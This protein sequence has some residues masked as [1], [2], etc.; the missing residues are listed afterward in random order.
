VRNTSKPSFLLRST[1]IYE[2]QVKQTYY[3]RW[4]VLALALFMMFVGIVMEFDGLHGS[5]N[6]TL[7]APHLIN[8]NLKNGSPG[9]A[10]VMMGMV[11][12]CV[13]VLSQPVKLQSGPDNTL[14]IHQ[15]NPFVS[16]FLR[17]KKN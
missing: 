14:A 12:C 16:L 11:L 10:L 9:V 1:G 3:L 4:A 13:V 15:P 6:L 17:H 8:T 5:V 2:L 7:D